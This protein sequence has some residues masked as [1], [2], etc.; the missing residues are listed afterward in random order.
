MS[1]ATVPEK[2]AE[3][4]EEWRRSSSHTRWLLAGSP[5]AHSDWEQDP[6]AWH[7]ALAALR[8]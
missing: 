2:E 7:E 1:E 5:W 4:I 8:D 3:A 6:A